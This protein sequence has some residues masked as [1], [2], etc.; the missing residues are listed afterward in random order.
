MYRYRVAYTELQVGF[1]PHGSGWSLALHWA[2]YLSLFAHNHGVQQPSQDT[3]A[4]EVPFPGSDAGFGSLHTPVSSH[5][6]GRVAVYASLHPE[7]CGRRILNVADSERPT[8]FRELWPALAAW[9]G[10]VGVGP[11]DEGSDTLK[12]GEYVARHR[13]V[14]EAMG[15]SKAASGGVGV[16]SAQLDSVGSW[17]TFDRQLGLGRLR[18][19]GYVEERDPVEGWLEAFAKFRGAG[20]IL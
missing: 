11:T 18:A 1:T 10:L 16:G 13:Q 20:I 12:P 9:F 3:Q 6:L 5:T 19:A 7:Q 4:V 2:Q 17:L 8:S 15:L 14:F